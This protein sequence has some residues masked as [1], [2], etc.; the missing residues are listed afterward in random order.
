M[1]RGRPVEN[2]NIPKSKWELNCK[3]YTGDEI[4][5]VFNAKDNPN[6]VSSVIK[7]SKTIKVNIDKKQSYSP[8][9][10]VMVFKSNRKNAKPKMK[11][12]NNTNID[13]I[14]SCENLPGVPN[15]AEILELAVGNKFENEFKNKYQIK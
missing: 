7:S 10:V 15:D 13:Y 2:D 6:G 4:K 9:P 8:Q 12:W 14:N 5:Y 1:K 11:I 3:S